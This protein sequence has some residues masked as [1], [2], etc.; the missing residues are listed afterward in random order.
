[1]KKL[2]NVFILIIM[3]SVCSMIKINAATEEVYNIVTCPG[4]NMATQMQINWQSSSTITDLKIEYTIESDNEF[5]NSKIVKGQYHQFSRKDSDPNVKGT[6]TGFSTPRN[7]WNASLSDLSPKTNYIYRVVNDTKIYS[8]IFSFTTASLEDDEF[9]FL[10]MTDPQFYEEKGASKFNKMAED[11][12]L[13]SDIKFSL[14]TGD[15]SDHGGSSN[16]WDMFF[17]KSSLKKLPY[18]TTVGNHEYYDSGTVTTD[19]TIYN[20]FF[21]N[22][23]NGPESVKGSSYYFVY[24]NALFIMLDSEAS[25]TYLSQ[26]KTWFRN[27]CKNVPASYIIVGTHKSAYAGAHYISDGKSFIAKWGEVLDECQVD[28]VLSGHDHMYARTKKLVGGEV[29][30]DIYRGTTFILGGS[31]GN[32]YYSLSNKENLSKWAKYFDNTTCCTLITLGKE[33]LKICAYSYDGEILDSCKIERKRFGTVDPSFT[34]D[35]FEKSFYFDNISKNKTSGTINWSSKGYGYVN[36]M[37]FTNLNSKKELGNVSIINTS[38]NSL[39][40]KDEFWLGEINKIQVDIDY[41]DGSKQTVI[42]ELDNTIEW[43]VIN[44]IKAVDI[45]DNSFNLVLS[46]DLKDEYDYLARIRV[47]ENGKIKKNFSIKIEHL[48]QNEIVIE[49][50]KIMEPSSSHNYVIELL[51]VNGTVIWSQEISVTSKKAFTEEELYQNEMANIAFKAML[52]NLLKALE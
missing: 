26:Q 49:L 29:T 15:I 51:N 22:P 20:Q 7:V 17:S 40:I 45:T 31:A 16:L 30:T 46:V 10:F 38:T 47:T 18:A 13:K 3:L 35:E 11:H 23:Q 12:I 37:T 28:L 50:K 52:D 24:N 5:K 42:L 8:D 19:N 39:T 43:G 33:E 14:I 32:K 41:F 21:Y 9:S 6:Y 44:S 36:T 1:M 4:E 25:S 34:K 27:V 2:L 48:S